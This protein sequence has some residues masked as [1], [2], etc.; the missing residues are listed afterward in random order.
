MSLS[1]FVPVLAVGQHDASNEGA[2]CGREA[3]ERH[4]KRD[5]YHQRQRGL[6]R[7]NSRRPAVAMKR[8]AGRVR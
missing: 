7:T 5:T 4:Q 1:Q 3:D 6:R 2:K 8:N